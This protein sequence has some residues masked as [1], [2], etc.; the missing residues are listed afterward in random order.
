MPSNVPVLSA[1]LG[2]V[3][4]F[5]TF[6]VDHAGRY[7]S[8]AVNY[9]QWKVR[10]QK[11]HSRYF[12]SEE[13]PGRTPQR[14]GTG[15]LPWRA[16]AGAS[17]LRTAYAHETYGCGASLDLIPTLNGM[18]IRHNRTVNHIEV[19]SLIAI[20]EIKRSLIRAKHDLQ[21]V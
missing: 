7:G 10:G 8:A 21:I 15:S 2:D 19:R 1:S 20:E 6:F 4:H 13:Q 14:Q 17:G 16:K 9:L 5:G 11:Q 18:Y 12:C 3:S